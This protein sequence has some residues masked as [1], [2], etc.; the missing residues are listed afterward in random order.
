MFSG[1]LSVFVSVITGNYWTTQFFVQKNWA[2]ASRWKLDTEQISLLVFVVASSAW[3][4]REENFSEEK[5][6]V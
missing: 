4:W 5:L 6:I 2:M 1:T 3:I